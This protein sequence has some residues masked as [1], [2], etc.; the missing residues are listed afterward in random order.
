M[1]IYSMELIVGSQQWLL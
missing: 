1:P